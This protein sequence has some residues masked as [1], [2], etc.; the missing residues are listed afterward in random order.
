MC[1]KSCVPVCVHTVTESVTEFQVMDEA[2]RVKPCDKSLASNIKVLAY[3]SSAL[4][5]FVNLF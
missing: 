4:L 5:C 1:T 2:G 3:T